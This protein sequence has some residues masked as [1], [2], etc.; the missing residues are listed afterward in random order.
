MTGLRTT[1]TGS[2][3]PR[4]GRSKGGARRGHDLDVRPIDDHRVS[5][6]VAGHV[7]KEGAVLADEV[8]GEE[9]EHPALVARGKRGAR[10]GHDPDS[11]VSDGNRVRQSVAGHVRESGRALPEEAGEGPFRAGARERNPGR[12]PHAPSVSTAMASAR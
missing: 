3:K 4:Y 12:Q 10:G 6:A 9:G 8:L 7:R 11:V 5:L 1:D 2:R